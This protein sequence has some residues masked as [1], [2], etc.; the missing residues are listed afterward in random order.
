MHGQ[1]QCRVPSG[2]DT[3]GSP[4]SPMSHLCCCYWDAWQGA[5]ANTEGQAE[6]GSETAGV[7]KVLQMVTVRRL[8]PREGTGLHVQQSKAGQ[9]EACCACDPLCRLCHLKGV[10]VPKHTGFRVRGAT[11]KSSPCSLPAGPS[12]NRY[13]LGTSPQ[14][15]LVNNVQLAA[16]PRN[17]QSSRGG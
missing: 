11:Y 14:P 5:P 16:L 2:N 13:V 1:A 7:R 9:R 3:G 15:G 17:A 8:R 4:L 10:V 12:V 6:S